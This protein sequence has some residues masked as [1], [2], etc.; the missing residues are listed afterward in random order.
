VGDAER[1]LH[2]TFDDAFASVLH[3]LPALERLGVPVTIFACSDYARDGRPLDVPELSRD[4]AS[5]P[6]ELATMDWDALRAIADRGVEIGSHTRTH[7]HLTW[8]S[9]DE[10]ELELRE[11]RTALEKKLWRPCRFLAYPYGEEDGRVRAAAKAAGYEA[12]FALH[13]DERDVDPFALPRVALFRSDRNRLRAA[14]KTT[15]T[16]RRVIRTVVRRARA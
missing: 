1:V 7:P 3:A 15:P 8:L 13:S 14:L 11:S 12:A 10:L 16:A 9:D 2:V 6:D 4:A 5:L